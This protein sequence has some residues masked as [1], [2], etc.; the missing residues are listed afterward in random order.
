M[1]LI[2]ISDGCHILGKKNPPKSSF[3]EKKLSF[4]VIF[5]HFL[6]KK[7]IREMPISENTYLTS[8]SHNFLKKTPFLIP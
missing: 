7:N 3:L 8:R 1:V 6:Y 5:S 2:E 4:G